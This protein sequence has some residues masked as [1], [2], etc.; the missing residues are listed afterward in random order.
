VTSPDAALPS[1]EF[2]GVARSAEETPPAEFEVALGRRRQSVRTRDVGATDAD[3]T[4]STPTDAALLARA[5]SGDRGAFGLL[6]ERHHR[7]LAAILRPSCGPAVAIEDL[8]QEVFARTLTHVAGFRSDAS[9]LTWATSIGLH[10]ASD[11]R[12]TADR[13]RRLAP[14]VDIADAEPPSRTDAGALAAVETRDDVERARRALDTLPEPMRV[15]VTLRIVEDES[16]EEIAARMKAPMPRVRQWVCRGLKRL[17]E[18][19]EE[20]HEGA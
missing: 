7:S 16:Y 3:A 9:F 15:A 13:R 5:Q 20:R 1:D 18:T 14:T 2:R 11:W 19:L 10:L 6:V 8:L 17:R 4:T 12:R